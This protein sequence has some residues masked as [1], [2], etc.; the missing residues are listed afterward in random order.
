MIPVKFT[1]VT[2]TLT[3][4]PGQP[5]TV[6]AVVIGALAVAYSTLWLTRNMMVQ[7]VWRMYMIGFIQAWFL[8]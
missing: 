1:T 3:V 8:S 6:A 5:V 7:K 2:G 4:D